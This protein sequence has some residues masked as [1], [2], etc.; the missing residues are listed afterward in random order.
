VVP[1][2]LVAAQ[3]EAEGVPSQEALVSHLAGQ[4]LVSPSV[5][6]AARSPYWR[7]VYV[8]VPTGGRLL[9]GYVD[10]LYRTPDGLVVIDYK[11]ASDDRP[12]ELDR[13]TDGYGMQGASYAWAVGQA[14]GEPVVRVTFVY[15]TPGGPAE[16]HLAD[17]PGAI[18]AL[19]QRIAERREVLV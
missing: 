3:C 11:T 6:E 18:E 8:C 19:R 7:E 10:L 2:A 4:A 9:E 16:R 14:T 17:L 15:L 5:R 1:A 12:D 13:R